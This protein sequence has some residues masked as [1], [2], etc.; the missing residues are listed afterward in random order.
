MILARER[1]DYFE[2]PLQVN[3]TRRTKKVMRFRGRTRFL[4]AGIFLIAF[5]LGLGLT[6][7]YVQVTATG[8]EI[9]RMKKELKA[10]EL[11]NQRLEM[12]LENLQTLERIESV[13]INKLG[14]VKPDPQAGV[15]FV[16]IESTEDANPW[17]STAGQTGARAMAEGNNDAMN[18]VKAFTQLVAGW[19]GRETAAEAKPLNR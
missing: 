7:R 16:A 12:Q 3:Q 14:M 10:M 19:T 5:L 13:A 15:Q 17:P 9:V 4:Y 11:E 2:Q 18:I 1:F 8:Y 6:W